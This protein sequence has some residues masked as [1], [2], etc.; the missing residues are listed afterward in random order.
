VR[1]RTGGWDSP[2]LSPRLAPRADAA[3]GAAVRIE[4]FRFGGWATFVT[5]AWF[6]VCGAV[7]LLLS[8]SLS[9]RGAW[10]VRPLRIRP[11]HDLIARLTTILCMACGDGQD[12]AVLAALTYSGMYLTNWCACRL[13][14]STVALPLME[15]LLQDL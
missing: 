15:H 1:H 10:R 11:W 6:C 8:G 4:G 5:T 7:E 3:V 12:Y 14:S 13:S 2:R 9:R